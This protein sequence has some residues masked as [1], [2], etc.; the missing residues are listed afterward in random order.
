MRTLLCLCLAL[1]AGCAGDRPWK[2][3]VT[4]EAKAEAVEKAGRPEAKASAGVS[5]KWSR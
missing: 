1:V 4:G 5:F 3:E 2:Q